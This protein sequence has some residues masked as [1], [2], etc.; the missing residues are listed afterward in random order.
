[1]GFLP[2]SQKRHMDKQK[3]TTRKSARLFTDSEKRA[4]V[5]DEFGK[6]LH[7]GLC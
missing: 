6:R 2:I 7:E 5:A 1:M 4:K 3:Q